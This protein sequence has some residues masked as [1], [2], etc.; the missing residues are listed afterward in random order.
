[1]AIKLYACVRTASGTI[2]RRQNFVEGQQPTL[3]PAKGLRWIL[4]EPPAF[5]AASQRAV[6]QVP[7]AENATQVPY[8]V[9]TDPA[10]T[11]RVARQNA[12]QK[13]VRRVE[14]LRAKGDLQ[15]RIE[16]LELIEK[17]TKSWP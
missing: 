7:I 8:T 1:M 11:E 16:A 4:D 9:E 17:E 14:E 15:S 6:V 10:H 5:D 3:A 13:I 2:E 12:R